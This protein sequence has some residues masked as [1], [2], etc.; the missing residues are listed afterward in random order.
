M[1]RGCLGFLGDLTVKEDLDFLFKI[2]EIDLEGLDG[3][4]DLGQANLFVGLL[5]TVD[6]LLVAIL[7]DD[8]ATVSDLVEAQGS[9]R[10]LQKMTE[11][12]QLIEVLV[13]PE[14]GRGEK[15]SVEPI[16]SD[17]RQIG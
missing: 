15:R 3:I 12:G 17:R 4:G 16:R 1:L 11:A 9:R 2:G 5:G 14:K 8:L 10:T 7:L 13:G 6:G